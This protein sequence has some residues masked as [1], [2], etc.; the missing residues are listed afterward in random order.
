MCASSS[1]GTEAFFSASGTALSQEVADG[2]I[3]IQ[4]ARTL[5]KVYIYMVKPTTV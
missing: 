4:S 1:G 2:K 5:N 3:N